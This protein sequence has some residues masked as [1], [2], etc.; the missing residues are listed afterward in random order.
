MRVYRAAF[1]PALVALFVVAFALEN[2]P[3][4]ATSRLAAQAFDDS[5]AFGPGRAPVR[6]SL[7]ELG[8]AFPSRRPGSD[9]DLGVAGRVET[10]L[11]TN[12]FRVSRSD[13]DGRTVDGRRDLTTV[14]GVRPGL[15]ARR[16]V[17][18]AHRDSV[19]TQGLADL[20]GTAALI[21]LARIFR[22][23]S[24]S[25]V[26]PGESSRL[27]GRDLAKTLVL[28]STSGGSGGA[29][30]ARA[31][32]REAGG[33]DAVLV[34]GDLA[35][36]RV[37]KPWVVPWSNSDSAPP[38]GLRRTVEAAVR[39]EVGSQPGG[40]RAPAQ[41][42]RRAAPAT[43]SEQG[44]VLRSGLP[45]VELSVSGER[46]P[47][48]GGRILQDRL[49]EFGRAALRTVTAVDEVGEREGVAQR[50][51]SRPAFAGETAGIVTMRKVLPDWAVRL[52]IGTLLLPALLAALDGFFRARRRRLAVG[53][54]LQ[55]IAAGAVAPVV[56]WLWTQ[57]L[58]AVGAFSPPPAPVM[59]DA[60]PFAIG[61][62]LAMLSTA[63]V[64]A[65]VWF[66][67]RPG[68]LRI[69]GRRGNAAAGGAAAALGVVVCGI[70]AVVWVANP[71][72]AALLLPAAHLW[73]FA[74]SPG[75]RL[76]GRLGV[77][78]LVAGLALPALAL[79][80]YA[81]AL[82]LGPLELVWWLFELVAGGHVSPATIVA[83]SLLGSCVGAFVVV[84]R[85]RERLAANIET[86]EP[87]VTRGPVSY[88]GPGSLGGTESA[89]KR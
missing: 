14:V 36:E 57:A 82:G 72:A 38:I 28:V 44:E 10:A 69:I 23:R 6:D 84:L 7:R 86:G 12:G 55:W 25:P 32:A 53:R 64:G 65:F 2:R 68:L 85:T 73:L 80:Y 35:G 56:A 61:G 46:G 21:E 60:T 42:I 48:P 45:A 5:R 87:I 47:D 49:G 31:W 4:P 13:V 77:V 50:A 71:F 75:S 8:N 63:L 37:R 22:S 52:L 83:W 27:V 39:Q 58:V 30:G 15:S 16:I 78:A 67:G 29:A 89:L 74:A 34:L 18:L 81:L 3:A 66:G 88:A 43:V 9:G 24:D 11:R 70:A 62:A 17:V 79:L 20:S 54:W 51:G 33:I 41:W 59:P 76:R 26:R 40:A 1:L 19:R